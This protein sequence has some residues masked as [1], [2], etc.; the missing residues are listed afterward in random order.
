MHRSERQLMAGKQA[1]LY[2][3][4]LRSCVVGELEHELELELELA[5][6]RTLSSSP[7]QLARKPAGAP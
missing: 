3:F 1:Y 5:G 7:R 6:T 4:R 2:A